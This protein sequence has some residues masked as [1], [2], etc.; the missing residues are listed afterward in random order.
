VQ[1][2]SGRLRVLVGSITMNKQNR[3]ETGRASLVKKKMR[4]RN[5]IPG[6]KN[7]DGIMMSSSASRADESL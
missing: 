2:V 7:M 4:N 1:P 3:I 6:M 5:E